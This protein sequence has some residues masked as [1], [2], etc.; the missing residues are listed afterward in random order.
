MVGWMWSS[1]ECRSGGHPW[2]TQGTGL[3][4]TPTRVYHRCSPMSSRLAPSNLNIFGFTAGETEAWGSCSKLLQ[5]SQ[6]VILQTNKRGRGDAVM[7]HSLGLVVS[8]LK[9]SKLCGLHSKA[10]AVL[11]A[12]PHQP[13]GQRRS[14]PAPWWGAALPCWTYWWWF[15]NHASS[16][17]WA[18]LRLGGKFFP[19]YEPLQV[20]FYNRSSVRSLIAG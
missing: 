2:K 10:P 1:Q 17:C 12:H 16:V 6:W 13:H 8:R 15:F 19:S 9:T 5:V 20:T 7:L 14:H 11:R 4:C 3:P 18:R